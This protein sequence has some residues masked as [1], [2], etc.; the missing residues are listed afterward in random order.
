M[1]HETWDLVKQNKNFY[2]KLYRRGL[3][4]LNTLLILS[5]LLV[6]SIF[7]LKTHEPIPDFYATN[8]ITAPDKLK[9]LNAP[10]ESSNALLAPDKTSVEGQKLIPQ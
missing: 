6:W 8:G 2:V 1:G 9:P 5:L 4:I 3:L 7:Y 10:N